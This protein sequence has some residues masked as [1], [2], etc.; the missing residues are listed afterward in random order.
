MSLKELVLSTG[1][2]LGLSIA[3]LQACATSDNF[4]SHK[5][6]TE[7][8]S[9]AETLFQSI[10]GDFCIKE[11]TYENTF[12]E[13]D[14]SL[15]S[16][17]SYYTFISKEACVASVTGVKGKDH[18]IMSEEKYLEIYLC[19]TKEIS[20]GAVSIWDFKAKSINLFSTPYDYKLGLGC[21]CEKDGSIVSNNTIYLPME[22]SMVGANGSTKNIPINM[23]KQEDYLS[24]VIKNVLVNL[25]S[26]CNNLGE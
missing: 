10:R 3:N 16:V 5:S 20:H 9:Q 17:R 14:N 4:I 6:E 22:I 18:D 15:W 26:D 7:S 12:K 25:K 13:N 19:D 21:Y 8:L 23:G 2:A 11:K 1:I 24:Y